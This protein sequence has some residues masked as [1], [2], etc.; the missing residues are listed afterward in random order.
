MSRRQ[1]SCKSAGRVRRRPTT[2]AA[3]K[4]GRGHGTRTV[5]SHGTPSI[6]A[7]RTRAWSTATT[8]AGPPGHQAGRRGSGPAGISRR[9]NMSRALRSYRDQEYV[10]Q[11][12]YLKGPDVSDIAYTP[13]LP[14]GWPR[15]RGFTHAIA[16]TGTRTVRVAG[17]VAS[18]SGAPVPASLDIGGQWQQALANVITVVRAAGGDIANIILLRAFVTDVE[19]FK[20]AGP[21]I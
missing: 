7:G 19:A 18:Q 10:A 3:S 4:A 14:E 13:I 17:Q 1:T 11:A 6:R 15:P 12:T 21:A 9:R 2:S 16:A 8:D 5:M 20:Q